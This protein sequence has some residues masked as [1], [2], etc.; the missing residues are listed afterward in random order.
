M[1]IL[2]LVSFLVSSPVISLAQKPLQ[3]GGSG[4]HGGDG[5]IVLEVTEN[6]GSKALNLE[7][8]N[9]LLLTYLTKLKASRY[10]SDKTVAISWPFDPILSSEFFEDVKYPDYKILSKRGDC[11]FTKDGFPRVAATNAISRNEICFDSQTIQDLRLTP[12]HMI[13]ILAHEH[14]HH[15]KSCQD[16]SHDIATAVSATFDEIMRPDDDARCMVSRS[17]MNV[18]LTEPFN[19]DGRSIHETRSFSGVELIQGSVIHGVLLGS[20]FSIKADQDFGPSSFRVLL[21]LNGKSPSYVYIARTDIIPSAK[22]YLKPI[23]FVFSGSYTTSS[24]FKEDTLV[25][26]VQPGK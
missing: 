19:F 14:C 26:N 2:L 1:K 25:C 13:G 18:N 15:I 16:G 23:H 5:R 22:P 10:R 6:P 7:R 20:P 3:K 24:W 8:L 21:S 9:K 11:G 4:S 17:E 12:V